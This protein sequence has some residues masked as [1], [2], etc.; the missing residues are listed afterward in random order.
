[1]TVFSLPPLNYDYKSLNPHIDTQ[2]MQLH[3]DLHH[4]A[5]INNLNKE[6]A[7]SGFY[8]DASL[9]EII[10]NVAKDEE[11]KSYTTIRNN[12]GGHY[13]HSLFWL[14]MSPKSDVKD[15]DKELMNMINESFDNFDA[16]KE[17]FNETAKTV[18]GSGWAWLCYNICDKKLEIHS[19]KNQD[20][21]AM[22]NSSCLPILC[23]DVWEHAYYL[24]YQNKRVDY[25]AAFWN[26]IDWANVSQFFLK[27]AKEGRLV[28]VNDDGTVDFK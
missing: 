15:I 18:F 8:K 14:M 12:A 4:Q 27:Y 7:D 28:E 1:M 24:K 2:T 16:M 3:H 11:N 20:N 9:N 26:I 10:L 19:S 21:P 25:I 22:F 5:Y 17:K 6:I 23:I 13:N